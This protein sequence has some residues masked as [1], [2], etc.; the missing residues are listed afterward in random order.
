MKGEDDSMGISWTSGAP[1]RGSRHAHRTLT[2]RF[3]RTPL[4]M[5]P[6]SVNFPSTTCS[7]WVFILLPRTE[8]ATAGVGI[9]IGTSKIAFAC[10]ER[11]RAIRR[12]WLAMFLFW[13]AAPE[14]HVR[15]AYRASNIVDPKAESLL[16]DLRMIHRI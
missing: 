13:Q 5:R 7:T 3:S 12:R 8:C 10:M 6:W 11:A 14:A 16:D 2:S 4:R 1:T 9:I 15:P